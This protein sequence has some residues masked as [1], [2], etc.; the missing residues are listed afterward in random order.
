MQPSGIPCVTTEEWLCSEHGGCCQ[1][2]LLGLTRTPELRCGPL[3]NS[4]SRGGTGVHGPIKTLRVT[5]N[6]THFHI[7]CFFLENRP[8]RQI[9]LHSPPETAREQVLSRLF[10]CHVLPKVN[11][12]K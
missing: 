6:L 12:Q 11:E 5:D 7:A 2:G 3:S 10:K 4:P 1:P 8:Q 9:N